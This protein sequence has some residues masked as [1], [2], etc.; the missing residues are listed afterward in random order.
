[1]DG[2]TFGPANALTE[3]VATTTLTIAGIVPVVIIQL[4]SKHLITKRDFFL[5]CQM[6]QEYALPLFT[7]SFITYFN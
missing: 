2:Q 1:M 3:A 7:I 6:R 4:V 5:N